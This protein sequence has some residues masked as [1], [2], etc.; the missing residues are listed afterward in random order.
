M[1]DT[2]HSVT[3]HC[4]ASILLPLLYLEL[5]IGRKWEANCLILNL[6]TTKKRPESQERYVQIARYL[7]SPGLHTA[8]IRRDTLSSVFCIHVPRTVGL[9]LVWRYVQDNGAMS[10]LRHRTIRTRAT[11]YIIVTL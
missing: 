3:S 2:G 8:T 6:P 10:P 9:L 4:P 1:L 5:R 7:I 11:L